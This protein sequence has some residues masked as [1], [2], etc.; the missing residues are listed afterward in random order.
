[1]TQFP[2][3]GTARL[4]PAHLVVATLLTA[5]AA[6]LVLF[7]FSPGGDT[8]YL[9]Q[10]L[11]VFALCALLPGILLVDVIVGRTGAPPTVLER[12]VLSL[13]MGYAALATVL[14]LLSYLPGPLQTGHVL[15]AF[16]FLLAVLLVIVW[17]QARTGRLVPDAGA[18]DP[19]MARDFP[20]RPY[21]YWLAVGLA[22]AIIAGGVLRMG[23]LGYAEFHGDEA[24]AVLRAA[25]VIQGYDDVLFLHKKGPA[26]ILLPTASFALADRVTETTAR[27]PFALAGLTALLA[28][29]LLGNRMFGPLAGWAAAMLL[30]LD[31]YSVAFSRIVQYQSVV[32]LTSA[33]GVL[34]L[35]RLVRNPKASLNYLSLAAALLATGLMSHYEATFALAPMLFLWIV[36]LRRH[37]EYKRRLIRSTVFAGLIGVALT[38]LFYGPF[39]LHPQFRATY[40]YLAQRRLGFGGEAAAG[41]IPYNNLVDFFTRTTIYNSTYYL[42][43]LITMATIALVIAYRRGLGKIWGSI[44]GVAIV[45]G[46][47]VV[48]WAP[49]WLAMGSRDLTILLFATAL[50]LA[51]VMP[52]MPASERSLWLWLGIP[53]LLLLFFTAKPRTHVYIFF[54]PWTLLAGMT[55]GRI[56][57]ALRV[58]ASFRTASVVGATTAAAL[59]V[60]FGV[61]TYLYFVYHDVEILRTW[62]QNRPP[63]YWSAYDTLDNRALFGFPLAN[64]WKVAG[65]LYEEGEIEGSY[66]TNEVE[67]WTP[68]WYTRGR[69][70]CEDNAGWFFQIS[71][72]QPDPEGYARSIETYVSKDFAPWGQVTIAGDPRMII[73]RRGHDPVDVQ[74]YPLESFEAAFDAAA[75]ADL[76]LSYPVV[77][78]AI[79]NALHA[80]FSDA[81]WL[82]GYDLHYDTPIQPGDE[83]SLTLYWRAQRPIEESYKVFNQS[84]YGDGVMIAQQ[85]GFPVCGARGTWLWDPG[86]LIVDRHTITVN[87]DAPPGLYPLYTGL[88]IPETFE[89]LD[90]LDE[91]GNV[92]GDK[93][94]LTDIRV[95]VE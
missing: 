16:D 82:E 51:W 36:A 69:Y 17:L 95:G 72:P 32:I 83:L 31:G 92:T 39:V 57:L 89:R 23:N 81:I 6:H 94:H 9:L 68:A 34:I 79:T 54:T 5:I 28:V 64:G 33:L 75:T 84:Y 13:G 19:A 42:L 70:R 27:L 12:V 56:W 73:H 3:G 77:E 62:Q 48:I 47:A 63:G 40:T 49:S 65:E 91:A 25:A 15:L 14:L 7:A 20:I 78:P 44:L 43:L 85:D 45:L 1:M 71:N 22:L 24:R 76:P 55:I 10:S 93:V 87:A 59:V 58:Y 37:P 52:H 50:A 74:T 26:E 67:F 8:A 2:S 46:L 4:H 53:L 66:A 38:T 29:Y 18:I 61:Y 90:V 80:N 30:A 88:Y 21:T 35:Y 60:L 86:E 11:A 41:G